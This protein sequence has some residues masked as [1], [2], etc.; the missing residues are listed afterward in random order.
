MKKIGTIREEVNELDAL[1]I[2]AFLFIFQDPLSP[3]HQKLPKLGIWKS[4]SF[5]YLKEPSK[6]SV[7]NDFL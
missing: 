7:R 2:D 5:G 4:Q 1:G 6:S 3:Q